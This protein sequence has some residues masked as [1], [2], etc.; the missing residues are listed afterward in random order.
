MYLLD[1]DH[2]SLIQRGSAAG[3]SILQNLIASNTP[4]A[5]T[6]VTYEEQTRGWLDL[7]SRAKTLDEQVNAYQFLHQHTINYRHIT[8]ISC[9]RVALQHYQHLRS[10]YPRLGKMDL[11]I[12]AIALTTSATLLTRNHKDFGQITTLQSQDWSL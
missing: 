11:K 8:V 2:L 4:F 6:I 7:L 5:T 9:D 1:T 3:R 10:A 12:A